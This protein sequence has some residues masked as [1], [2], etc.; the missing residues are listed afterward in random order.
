VSQFVFAGFMGFLL[1]GEVPPALFYAASAIVVAGVA[2][3][4]LGA[5]AATGET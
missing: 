4:V 5:P 1:F 3:V 2:I